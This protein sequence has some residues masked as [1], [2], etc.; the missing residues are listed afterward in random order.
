VGHSRRFRRVHA[1]SGYPPKLT[2]EETWR[3][4]A[5]D[6]KRKSVEVVMT[7]VLVYDIRVSL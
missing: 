7:L 2:V 1:T 6:L 3:T 5:A 4:R